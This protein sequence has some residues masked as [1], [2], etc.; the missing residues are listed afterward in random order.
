LQSDYIISRIGHGS[1]H[2]VQ[3]QP[4]EQQTLLQCSEV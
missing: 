4:V 1:A 2:Q 3:R